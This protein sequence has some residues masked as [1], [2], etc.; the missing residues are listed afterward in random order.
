MPETDLYGRGIASFVLAVI[1]IIAV[2]PVAYLFAISPKFEHVNTT[3]WGLGFIFSMLAMIFSQFGKN[4]K[5]LGVAAELLGS[6]ALASYAIIGIIML[7][8]R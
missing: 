6:T 4:G 3:I 7:I 8:I 5:G 2:F 1:A